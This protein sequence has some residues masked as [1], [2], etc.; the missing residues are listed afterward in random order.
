V[1]LSAR[2]FQIS[3]SFRR[4]ILALGINLQVDLLF[5]RKL[6]LASF[7]F[8]SQ[9][10]CGLVIALGFFVVVDELTVMFLRGPA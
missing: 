5:V 2:E 4:I 9:V 3:F 6:G 1:T 7:R 8:R 10:P